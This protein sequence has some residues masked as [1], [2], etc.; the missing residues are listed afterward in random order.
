MTWETGSSCTAARCVGWQSCSWVTL[1]AL[2]KLCAYVRQV[3]SLWILIWHMGSICSEWAV[4]PSWWLLNILNIT[5]VYTLWT[6][7]PI[8][9]NA[10]Q[11]NSLTYIYK[12][13]KEITNKCNKIDLTP[14][15]CA[16]NLTRNCS[17]NQEVSTTGDY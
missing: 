14:I 8:S 4:P 16:H 11:R 17:W 13:T 1:V 6:S 12:I 5:R 2:I 7:Y 9:K 3:V 10:C 15:K